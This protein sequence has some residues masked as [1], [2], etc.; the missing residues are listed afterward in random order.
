MKKDENAASAASHALLAAR[1]E[2]QSFRPSASQPWGV[3][4]T[5]SFSF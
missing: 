3:S 1:R 2:A 4:L 5:Y